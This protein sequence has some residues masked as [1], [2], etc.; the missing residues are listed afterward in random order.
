QRQAVCRG[1]G[2]GAEFIRADGDVA[3]AQAPADRLDAVR[4][5]AVNKHR[6]TP[7]RPWRRAGLFRTGPA[8]ALSL[9][10]IAA[11][12]QSPDAPGEI[13]RLR[14][15]LN[16]ATRSTEDYGDLACGSNGGPPRQKLDGWTGFRTCRPE[17]S[18]LREVYVRFDD[19][20]EYVGKAV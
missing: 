11:Q 1:A 9:A 20:D 7:A 18:G 10:S 19:T 15:G 13:R 12:A 6:R 3:R 14:L 17:P 2:G 5:R 16:A 4:V 8:L